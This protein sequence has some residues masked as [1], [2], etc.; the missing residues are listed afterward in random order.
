MSSKIEDLHP[1]FRPV[2]ASILAET[3][4]RVGDS[5]VRFANTFRS[6]ADQATALAAGKSKVS[7]GWH[8]FGLAFDVAI[9]SPEGVY[10][11]DGQDERYTMFGQEAVKAGCVWGGNWHGFPDPAHAEFHPGFALSHYIAWLGEHKVA[12]A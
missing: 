2:A 6:L 4:K 10:I 9:I 3:Q 12:V 11:A 5:T 1:L 7:L 8:Q